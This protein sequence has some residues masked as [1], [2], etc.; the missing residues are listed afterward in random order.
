MPKRWKIGV[1][2]DTTVAGLGDH[3]THRAFTGLP[4]VEIAL[5]DANTNDLPG[6]MQAIGAVRHYRDHRRMLEAEPFDIVVVC[7]RIPGEHFTVIQDAMDAGC[8]IYCE[9][10]LT[11]DLAEA[12]R[13][14]RLSEA[15]GAKLAVAHLARHAPVFRMLKRQLDAGAIGE[16]LAFYGRG[17]EDARGGGEDLMVLGTHILDIGNALFGH[18]ES[19]FADLSVDGRPLRVDDRAA[20]AEPIGPCAGDALFACFQYPGGVRGV[21]ESRRGLFDGTHVRMGITVAGTRGAMRVRFDNERRLRISHS[22][23]PPEDETA[24]T[25]LP[26]TEDRSIP[27]DAVPLRISPDG[28]APNA[29]FAVCNRFAALDLMAAIQEDRPPAA[30]VH[31]ARQVLEMI[32]GIYRSQ[33]TGS[34]MTFPLRL[35][36]HPLVEDERNVP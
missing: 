32:Y 13:L 11:T 31:H 7:S 23:V 22:P 20:T 4:H 5:A 27:A 26:L 10:P 29:Y 2:H 35:R 3:G 33:L 21:F 1:V 6:R 16:P 28:P 17:K 14:V 34:R 24:Y 25:E 36:A 19:V 12:D 15:R 8:H 30:N 18:P 9:K